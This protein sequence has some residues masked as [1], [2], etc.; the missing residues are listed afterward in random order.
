MEF[1]NSSVRQANK[2][3]TCEICTSD[4]E[5]GEKYLNLKYKFDG[6]F[7]ND[8]RHIIC[9]KII[10]Y[11]VEKTGFY[12][13]EDDGVDIEAIISRIIEDYNSYMS[14][15]DS[16]F[17]KK[18]DYNMDIKMVIDYMYKYVYKISD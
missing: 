5:K 9:S 11:I 18:E 3:H 6:D 2:K 7:Y 12:Y 17:K 8:H 16:N 4:I 1:S 13:Y 14:E 15:H 10:N